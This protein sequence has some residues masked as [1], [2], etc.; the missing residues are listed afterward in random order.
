M[1][2]NE[3]RDIVLNA[4]YGHFDKNRIPYQEFHNY[5]LEETNILPQRENIVTDDLRKNG[6][7]E[8]NSINEYQITPKGQELLEVHGGFIEQQKAQS[9]QSNTV[10]IDNRGG[11]FKGDVGNQSRGDLFLGKKQTKVETNNINPNV[12]STEKQKTLI[13]SIATLIKSNRVI[14]ALVA[15]VILYF[16]KFAL[17]K[18]YSPTS[19]I[20]QSVKPVDTPKKK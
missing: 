18:K 1:T 5:L 3:E 15:G 17:D 6:Y 20:Q 9:I 14:S 2:I 7:L 13:N 11:R 12:Q 4:L 19:P 8:L 16:V 10:L